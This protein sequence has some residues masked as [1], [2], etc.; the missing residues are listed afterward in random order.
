MKWVSFCMWPCANLVYFVY[1]FVTFVTRLFI[2][3]EKSYKCI[4]SQRRRPSHKPISAWYFCWNIYYYWYFWAISIFSGFEFDSFW[5]CFSDLLCLRVTLKIIFVITMDCNPAVNH[6]FL[7]N[8]YFNTHLQKFKT[9]KSMLKNI[10]V[11]EV[12]IRRVSGETVG[13]K[14]PLEVLYIGRALPILPPRGGIL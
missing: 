4:A 1:R 5:N 12:N 10:T 2:A 3:K 9:P 6:N 14:R 8:C 7:Q 13:R 11:V